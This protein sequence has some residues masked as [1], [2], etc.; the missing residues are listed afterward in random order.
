MYEIL[1][2]EDDLPKKLFSMEINKTLG[3]TVRNFRL[4]PVEGGALKNVCHRSRIPFFWGGG[5][6]VRGSQN[7]EAL[8]L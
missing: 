8:R 7:P 3:L 2:M 5:G 4:K 6:R 1:A